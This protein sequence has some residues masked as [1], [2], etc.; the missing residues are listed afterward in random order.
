MPV[1]PVGAAIALGAN[2]GNSS[3]KPLRLICAGGQGD[4]VGTYRYW[5]EGRDDP[6]Q[7]SMTYSGQFY[8]VCRELGAYG[9]AIAWHPRREVI[10][11]GVFLVEHRTIPFSKASGLRYH[12]GKLWMS[13]WLT[14]VAIRYRADAMVVGDGSCHW[15]AL[16]LLPLLGIAVIPTIHCVLW[17]INTLPR[18]RVQRIVH[19][20]DRPFWSRSAASILSA[21]QSI[22]RQIDYITNGTH[23]PIIDFL[24]TYRTGT[25]TQNL[26]APTQKKPFRVLFAGR[27]EANKGVFDLLEIA[28]RFK[29]T[30]RHDIRFDLCGTGSA[31]EELKAQ[32]QKGA[33]EDRFNV[34]G[35]CDRFAMKDMF[36]QSH[37]VVV[38]TTTDFVEG[39]NQVVVE[40]ILA[41]R[42]V[43]TSNVCP[44]LEYVREAVTE[45]PPDD[46]DA[47]QAAI[48]ALSEN[49][50]LYEQKRIA[51]VALQKQFYDESLGWA[52]AFR[53][54]IHLL[55]RP[56][57]RQAPKS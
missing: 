18:G 54:A 52:A 48:I 25:F 15:F 27:I 56:T 43:I 3:R 50:A 23:R 14:A 26:E 19:R 36:L 37:V 16:R 49:E 24:P 45:V 51:C 41:G 17:K 31:I 28:R 53:R 57:S 9:Y 2:V 29:T 35:H 21:S 38:P 7:V 13:L 34:H 33:L 6:S 5:R 4:I 22:S 32:V 44:A 42:P 40:G 46:V 11:D 30:G 10:K 39:F 47:Y 8:D 12:I 55:G 1:E 20:L